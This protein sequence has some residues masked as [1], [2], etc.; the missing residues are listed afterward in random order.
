M[1]LFFCSLQIHNHH[2]SHNLCVSLCWA[3]IQLA[4][5]IFQMDYYYYNIHGFLCVVMRKFVFCL[6]KAPAK[7]VQRDYYDNVYLRGASAA[8]AA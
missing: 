5:E 7:P 6:R 3:H 1:Q 2:K 4:R 8:A